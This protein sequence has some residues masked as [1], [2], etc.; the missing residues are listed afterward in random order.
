MIFT[1]FSTYFQ[2]AVESTIVYDK[3]ECCGKAAKQEK[4]CGTAAEK[5]NCTMKDY[6]T[7]YKLDEAELEILSE[8]QLEDTDTDVY[9]VMVHIINVR[10]N[11]VAVNAYY[12]AKCKNDRF[13]Y[14]THQEYLDHV[15]EMDARMELWEKKMQ[16]LAG[17]TV[18]EEE[19][20]TIT[21]DVSEFFTIVYM[22][23]LKKYGRKK[24]KYQ[25]PSTMAMYE[26]DLVYDQIESML[27]GIAEDNADCTCSTCMSTKDNLLRL[28][29]ELL[30]ADARDELENFYKET[31][32]EWTGEES[33]GES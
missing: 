20:I 32:T 4:R 1:G 12:G 5:R 7:G 14:K 3:G 2:Q 13:R 15:K 23:N 21:Q 22:E 29:K 26:A 28:A 11:S 24:I 16:E 25:K 30:G 18:R 6:A 33:E 9:S 27:G 17:I 19:G 10:L 8:T 31:V